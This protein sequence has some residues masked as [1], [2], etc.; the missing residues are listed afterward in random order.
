MNEKQELTFGQKA[1]GITF[2]P[3]NNDSVNRMKQRYADIIDDLNDMRNDPLTSAGVKRHCSQAITE[4]ETAQMRA[5]K[6]LTW[7]EV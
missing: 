5:V 1:V 7:V 4:A 2:N 3:S 6:A